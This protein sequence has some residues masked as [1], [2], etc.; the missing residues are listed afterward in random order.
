MVKG[1]HTRNQLN[2]APLRDGLPSVAC[3]VINSGGHLAVPLK[4]VFGS[5]VSL[6][7]YQ[8]LC[9]KNCEQIS[10]LHRLGH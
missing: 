2:D 6:F 4:F 3:L 5:V 7:R 8:V 1:R 10:V 9:A